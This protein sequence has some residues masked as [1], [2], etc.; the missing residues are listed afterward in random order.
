L[1]QDA[2]ELLTANL[3]L[4]ESVVAFACRRFRLRPEESEEIASIVNLKLVENDYAILRSFEGRSNLSTFIG[5][6]VERTVLDYRAHTWGKWHASAEAKRLGEVAIA[7]EELLH[8]DGRPFEEACP[9][10]IAR[11][12]GTTLESLRAIAARLRERTARKRDVPIDEAE[13]VPDE[14]HGVDQRVVNGERKDTAARV[15]QLLIAIFEQMP[16]DER[17]IFQLKFEQGLTVAQIARALQRDQKLLYRQI[18]RRTREIR[19]TIEQSGVESQDVLD[20]IGHDEAFFEFDFGKHEPRPSKE[21]DERDTA[22][23]EEPE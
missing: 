2:R 21:I 17:L 5:V 23:P 14:G 1:A 8:R 13:P 20:L 12:P 10:L 11:H 19:T 18:E 4:V 6:V 7:L 22:Q 16:D 9:I 3:S 15:R